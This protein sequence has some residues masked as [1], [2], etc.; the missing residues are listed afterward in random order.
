M[1]GRRVVPSKKATWMNGLDDGGGGLI[2]PNE[3]PSPT[4]FCE[5]CLLPAT[6]DVVIVAGEEVEMCEECR[7]VIRG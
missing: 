4:K 2:I 3:A 5:L 1:K 7:K 6:T